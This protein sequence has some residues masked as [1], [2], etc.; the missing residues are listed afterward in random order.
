MDKLKYQN[1]YHRMIWRFIIASLLLIT[2]FIIKQLYV[3]SQIAQLE[4]TSYIINIA[5]RQR[6]LS[7]KIIKD[8]ILIQQNDS[9]E[10]KEH[11]IN[12]IE[13]SL[14]LWNESHHELIDMNET[15]KLLGNYREK[16]YL[17]YQELDSEYQYIMNNISLFLQYKNNSMTDIKGFDISIDQILVNEEM[18]LKQMDAIVNIYEDITKESIIKIQV[19]HTMLFIIATVIFLF[20]SFLIVFPIFNYLKNS[21]YNANKSN[22]NLLKM[23]NTMKGALFVTNRS[24]DIIFMNEDANAIILTQESTQNTKNI[25]KQIEWISFDIMGCIEKTVKSDNRIENIEVKLF[26]RNKDVITYLLSATTFSF[27]EKEAVLLNLFDITA[28][29]NAEKVL[30]SMVTKDNLT[31]LYNRHFLEKIIVEEQERADR[32]EIPLSAILMDID[33]FKNINDQWGHPV[34]DSVL[35]L[36]ASILTNNVRSSDYVIRIGGEEF[37]I[38]M[39]NTSVKGATAAAKKVKRAIAEA[40]HPVIGQ[41][42][43][44][45]GVAERNRGE[46]YQSLYNRA[47]KALYIAKENG[48]NCVIEAKGLGDEYTSVSL[49]W[50]KNWNCGEKEIDKQH[51]E[52]FRMVSQLANYTYVIEEKRIILSC[53]EDIVAYVVNHFNY[54]EKVLLDISYEGYSDHK[55]IH[56]NLVKK[57]NNIKVDVEKDKISSVKAFAF[58]FDEVIMSHLLSE[59]I[60]FFPYIKN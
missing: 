18:Y 5:G 28:Q 27:E 30:K 33:Y 53:L 45:F 50:N 6:M 10:K 26:D 16:I 58:L 4:D 35:Q 47:D 2:I 48:R 46:D 41:F 23:L 37:L 7:Q 52:L 55:K 21:F 3:Q 14:D 36:A 39:P 24:G 19:I 11:Y 12:D 43:A 25:S 15:D 31:N 20:I 1:I 38:L 57:A 40:K 49:K 54:E 9:S 51:Q 8:L 13:N 29:K 17:K 42:T 34:G 44:S 32:Y 59:D 56:D 22:E 60:K